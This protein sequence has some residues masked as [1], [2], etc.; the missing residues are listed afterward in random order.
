MQRFAQNGS[1]FVFAEHH[2][3]SFEKFQNRINWVKRCGQN[4]ANIIIRI[5]MTFN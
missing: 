1:K 4:F 3:I 2:V 5:G